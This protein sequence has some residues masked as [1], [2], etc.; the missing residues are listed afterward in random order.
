V[1]PISRLVLSLLVALVGLAAARSPSPPPQPLRIC[2]ARDFDSLGQV[3]DAGLL[4]EQWGKA[5]GLAFSQPHQSAQAYFKGRGSSTFDAGIELGG[6]DHPAEVLFIGTGESECRL[7]PDAGLVSMTGTV[8]LTNPLRMHTDYTTCKTHGAINAVVRDSSMD[9][10]LREL[11]FQ[12][13][14]YSLKSPRP[15]PPVLRSWQCRAAP[16]FVAL[17]VALVR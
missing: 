2:Q 15:F 10:G 17:I 12:F 13:R 11:Q 4:I 9:G 14:P 6:P 1:R 8:W 7:L 5:V 16:A 3:V